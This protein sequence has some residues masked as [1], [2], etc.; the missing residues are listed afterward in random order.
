MNTRQ[1]AADV[2]DVF[3]SPGFKELQRQILGNEVTDRSG[4]KVVKLVKEL[5]GAELDATVERAR[6]QN[7]NP[8]V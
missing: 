5:I 3:H 7:P 4:W 6:A 1:I 8:R 2:Q